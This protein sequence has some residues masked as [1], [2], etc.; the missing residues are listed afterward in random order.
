[1]IKYQITAKF[2][3]TF[4]VVGEDEVSF[5]RADELLSV[6]HGI[7]ETHIHK[8]VGNGSRQITKAEFYRD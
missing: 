2:G 7:R 6:Y 4:E 3:N 1:M 8:L 5:A